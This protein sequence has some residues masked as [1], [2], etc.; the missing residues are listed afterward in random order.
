MGRDPHPP[1]WNC[2]K[3]TMWASSGHLSNEVWYFH[4]FLGAG[5]L[6]LLPA[7][8]AK[9]AG[10]LGGCMGGRFKLQLPEPPGHVGILPAPAQ[11]RGVARGALLAA[12]RLLAGGARDVRRAGRQRPHGDL[13]R[14]LQ[15]F[16]ESSCVKTRARGAGAEHVS[17]SSHATTPSGA[18]FKSPSRLSR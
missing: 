10:R 7:N 16:R 18:V 8:A 5:L 14:V 2:V 13:V 9:Q 12:A 1:Q 17:S 3:K 4:G 6:I 15:A 11:H